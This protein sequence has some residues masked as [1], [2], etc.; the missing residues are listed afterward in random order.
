MI[1]QKIH[2][3]QQLLIT[4]LQVYLFKYFIGEICTESKV[5]FMKFTGNNTADFQVR[6]SGSPSATSDDSD[7]GQRLMI[8][9]VDTNSHVTG[10]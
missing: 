9:T 1:P 10:W 5:K 7:S 8:M 2:H 6:R 4:F 3:M